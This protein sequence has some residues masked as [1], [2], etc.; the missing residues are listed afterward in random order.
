M[1]TVVG[2]SL[3]FLI[4]VKISVVDIKTHFIHN[5]DL[6][7][8]FLIL[9]LF[10]EISIEN[11]LLNFLIYLIIYFISRKQLGFGDVKLALILGCSYQSVFT[12]MC[13]IN[14]SWAMGGVWALLSKQRRI[15]F[16]P[17]MLSGAC[18]AKILVA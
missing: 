3:L 8:L 1:F 16:A 2:Y 14:I 5:L 18:F 4:S 13:A 9:N 10:F 17:W 7:L 12:L 6:I 15:A 11:G